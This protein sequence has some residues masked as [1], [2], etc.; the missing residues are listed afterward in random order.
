MVSMYAPPAAQL[1]PAVQTPPAP[2]RSPTPVQPAQ[3]MQMPPAPAQPAPAVQTPTAPIQPAPAV[4]MPQAQVQ[5]APALQTP[6]AIATLSP[7]HSPWP[8]QRLLN[9]SFLSPSYGRAVPRSLFRSESMQTPMM[10]EV[11]EHLVR[12]NDTQTQCLERLNALISVLTGTAEAA[13]VRETPAQTL[14]AQMMTEPQIVTESPVLPGP[15][16]PN[17]ALFQIRSSST[18]GKNFAVRLVRHFFEPH[19]LDGRNVRGVGDK[20]PLNP[21]KMENI[22]KRI[23]QILSHGVVRKRSLLA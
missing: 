22:K 8:S 17:D 3:A 19:E 10:R 21:E 1:P 16:V 13:P 4:Q 15:V 14:P 6:P 2:A 23:I 5:P 11:L 12:I 7:M 9:S 20:L 18:S